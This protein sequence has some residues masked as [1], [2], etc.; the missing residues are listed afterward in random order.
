MELRRLNN[1]PF[2]IIIVITIIT[3]NAF[4]FF[5][6]NLNVSSS[7]AIY[8]NAVGNVTEPRKRTLKDLISPGDVY[9]ARHI[10]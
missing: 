9:G 5:A 2:F 1:T 10:L 7:V 6:R 8:A 4:F 3:I